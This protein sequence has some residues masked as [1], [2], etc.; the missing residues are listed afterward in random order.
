MAT[1]VKEKVSVDVDILQRSVTYTVNTV[2]QTMF[3]VVGGRG[4]PSDYLIER[5]KVIEDGLFTWLTEQALFSLHVEVFKR[6]E[7]KCIERWDFEFV[8][9]AEP[10]EKVGR[11]P[12][13]ELEQFMSKLKSLPAGA[14]YG[15]L[16]N[17]KAGYTEVPGWSP[18]ELMELEATDEQ[19]LNAWG[20]GNIGTTLIYRGS[21]K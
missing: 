16:A 20:Y 17:L 13:E 1:L 6:G 10:D 7:N 21:I 2:F 15:L 12:L 18:R 19:R 3:K 11:P 9:R 4:L 8:Y 5:R 14:Q